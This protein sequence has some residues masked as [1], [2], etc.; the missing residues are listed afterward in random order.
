MLAYGFGAKNILRSIA[1]YGCKI[2]VVPS[3]SLSLE[4]LHFSNGPGGQSAVPYAVKIVQD[5]VDKVPG[6]GICMGHQQLGQALGGSTFKTNF[7][8]HDGKS[9]LRLFFSTLLNYS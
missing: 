4:G 1:S 8:Q 7:G 9:V 6:F 2:T 5:L 3:T